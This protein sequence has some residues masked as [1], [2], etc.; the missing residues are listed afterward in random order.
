RGPLLATRAHQDLGEGRFTGPLAEAWRG[1]APLPA[2]L[3]DPDQALPVPAARDRRVWTETAL[4]AATLQ[5]LTERAKTDLTAP[6]PVPL[7]HQYARYFRDGHRD[8]Y[9][10]AV[11]ARQQRLSRA[12]VLAAVTQSPLWMDEVL[13]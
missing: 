7:P 10:Q 13:D 2:L 12:A 11:F 5:A 1:A 4:D 9:E 6:W 8:T 3:A